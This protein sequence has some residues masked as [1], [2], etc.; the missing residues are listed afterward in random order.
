MSTLPKSL[1]LATALFLLLAAPALARASRGSSPA[2]VTVVMR[3]PGCHWFSVGGKL[4]TA[5]SAKGP[6]SL[7]NFDEAA[8]KIV[9]AH[10]VVRDAVAGHVLLGKGLYRI[11]MVGQARDDNTLKLFVK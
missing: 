7:A 4:T 10:G 9:G 3:D 2:T 8:L 11:T 5:L 6:V 1:L